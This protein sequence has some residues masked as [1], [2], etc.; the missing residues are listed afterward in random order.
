MGAPLLMVLGILMGEG[1]EL[2]HAHVTGASAAALACACFG[3]ATARWVCAA[4]RG[5]Q[6]L[7]N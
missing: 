6:L 5:A 2:E 1:E 4:W 3:V 7:P